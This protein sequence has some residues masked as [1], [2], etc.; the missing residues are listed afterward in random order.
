[1]TKSYPH[2]ALSNLS[3]TYQI[4]Y[5]DGQMESPRGIPER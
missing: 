5:A 2:V 4:I 1:M 3:E